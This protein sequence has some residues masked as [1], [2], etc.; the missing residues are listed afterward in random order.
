MCSEFRASQDKRVKN[1]YR[2]VS[3]KKIP[4]KKLMGNQNFIILGTV[5]VC[6]ILQALTIKKFKISVD[7]ATSKFNWIENSIVLIT[8]KY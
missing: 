7:A 3:C 8:L 6:L 1:R 2:L 4:V 5:L